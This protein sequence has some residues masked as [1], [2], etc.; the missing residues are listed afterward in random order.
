MVVD[1]SRILVIDS[2]GRYDSVFEGIIN[3]FGYGIIVSTDSESKVIELINEYQAGIIILD[4]DFFDS[5]IDKHSLFQ[6]DKLHKIFV[7]NNYELITDKQFDYTVDIIY[8]ED[9]NSIKTLSFMLENALQKFFLGK[10]N[11]DYEETLNRLLTN[12]SFGI[13]ELDCSKF[14]QAVN[15]ISSIMEL[16]DYKVERNSID[17]LIDI[18]YVN[19]KIL[20]YFEADSFEY[21]D[22]NIINS[23]S[24]D[25]I[26]VFDQLTYLIINNINESEFE[27][28]FKTFKNNKKHFLWKFKRSNSGKSNYSK[29]SIVGIEVTKYKSEIELLG[30]LNHLL[31][32]KND[33]LEAKLIKVTKE[34]QT[35]VISNKLFEKRQ[36]SYSNAFI[37]TIVPLF[38]IDV[39]G[40]FSKINQA[41]LDLLSYTDETKLINKDL[42]YIFKNQDIANTIF[43]SLGTNGSFNS[44]VDIYDKDNNPKRVYLYSNAIYNSENEYSGLLGIVFDLT[45]IKSIEKELNESEEIHAFLINNIKDG[46]YMLEDSKITFI[47]DSLSSMIGYTPDE[48]YGKEFLQ[49]VLPEDRNYV[50]NKYKLMVSNQSKNEEYSFHLLHKNGLDKI[51]VSRAGTMI[52][53]KGKRILLGRLLNITNKKE[54]EIEL[55]RINEKLDEQVRI[56]TQGFLNANKML[57][58]EINN[59][60]KTEDIL[61]ESEL[62]LR[63]ISEYISDF[64]YSGYF[65]MDN[66]FQFDWIKGAFKGITGYDAEAIP[67]LPLGHLSII[68]PEDREAYISK[69]NMLRSNQ[70]MIMQYRV[71]KP[72][73]EIRW[74][75]DYLKP[76]EFN[77]SSGICRIIGALKDIDDTV[78]SERLLKENQQQLVELMSYIEQTREYEKKKLA[79]EL[80]NVFSHSLTKLKM[81]LT[82]LKSSIN[83]E[84]MELVDD[85]IESTENTITLIKKISFAIR[86]VMLDHFGLI[87]AIEWQIEELKTHSQI[88]FIFSKN[89]D[90]VEL[91][92][93]S[94][95]VVFR[96]L[97]DI[98]K[99]AVQHSDATLI[100]ISIV[101]NINLLTIVIEDNGI[102]FNFEEKIKQKSF[103]LIS[104][105]ER[106]KYCNA[107]IVF[108]SNSNGT[109][110]VLFFETNNI[111]NG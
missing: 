105:L 81:E 40:N 80:Q 60:K 47:N 59:R 110:V 23:F 77:E 32:V 33:E 68:M 37:G 75:K 21:F 66:K 10:F 78:N 41:L 95:T 87:A 19:P 96:I 111:T 91:D 42:S 14:A 97:Q 6:F 85:I 74:V 31:E 5:F 79:D 30:N 16:K 106:A 57:M 103:G 8:H 35:E 102:G 71:K 51:L 22:K 92:S 29:I 62:K 83:E 34:Y 73:G 3:K 36:F 25:N 48:I 67:Y 93:K 61:R 39:S 86:P 89:I 11:G 99:N 50:I 107:D 65:D 15:D 18:L 12:N 72:N 70:S 4:F 27:G 49:F 82:I 108:N 88:E 13:I 101:K 52:N 24:E 26:K 90:F 63:I 94:T 45:H 84:N 38:F 7:T 28:E 43:S 44:E 109:K 54:R 9:S 17:G 1:Y 58:K 98:I 69:L 64:V 2:K 104:I 76:I 55:K 20:E 46:I 100:Q 56:R 53:Y